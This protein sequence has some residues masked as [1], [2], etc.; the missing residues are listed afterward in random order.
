MLPDSRQADVLIL[1]AGPAGCAAALRLAELGI[2]VTLLTRPQ[3][4]RRIESLTPDGVQLAENLGLSHALAAAALGPVDRRCM[5][6]GAEAQKAAFEGDRKPLLLDRSAFHAAL[7]SACR[8]RGIAVVDASVR[9]VHAAP[10]EDALCV[11]TAAGSWSARVVL[12]AR[13]RSGQ[14]GVGTVRG[15]SLV[16]VPFL[17]QQT[18][19]REGTA[20]LIEA[21]AEGWIWACHHPSGRLGG[22]FFCDPALLRGGETARVGA[23]RRAL[24]A[25]RSA[26]AVQRL[27]IGT[28][29]DASMLAAGVGA[30]GGRALRIGDC[31]LARDPVTAHG[32]AHA[33]R[34]GAQA[35]AA[36]A[37]ILHPGC[38]DAAAEAFLSD[39]HAEAAAAAGRAMMQAYAEQGRVDGPFWAARRTAP[40]AIPA[41]AAPALRGQ[42]RVNLCAPM[43][44]AAV[45]E[46]GLIRWASAL[47]MP[48]HGRP[49]ARLGPAPAGAVAAMLRDAPPLRDLADRLSSAF[50]ASAGPAIL[51]Q[52]IDGGALMSAT[53]QKPHF[54]AMAGGAVPAA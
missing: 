35:A 53:G 41:E 9:S 2:A 16:A 18:A 3:T 6:W 39:R 11:E 20:M 54:P 40:A 51:R 30:I 14:A 48:L 46:D 1:G 27:D 37:T 52:L 43:I 5:W 42:D 17:G 19:S 50:G 44:R 26:N 10:A 47:Q 36:V 38:D 29:T 45:L 15:P 34:S 22:A 23:V 21:V 32:I 31:A 33:L 13:G 25:G 28:P 49:A 12:D 24:G 8:A 4:A 7:R